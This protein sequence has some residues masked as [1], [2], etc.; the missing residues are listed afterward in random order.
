MSTEALHQ[1]ACSDPGG[2]CACGP[3]TT[4]SQAAVQASRLVPHG[5]EEDDASADTD[6]DLLDSKTLV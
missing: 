4:V 5:D 3:E 2:H 6:E 1:Q